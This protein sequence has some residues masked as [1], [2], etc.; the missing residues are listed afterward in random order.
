MT[1]GD[2]TL[3]NSRLTEIGAD[4]NVRIGGRNL[5]LEPAAVVALE[6]AGIAKHKRNA[7][8]RGIAL[9]LAFD[10]CRAGNALYVVARHVGVVQPRE[11]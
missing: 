7:S 4:A 6:M 2:L 10:Q 3:G 11:T 9:L 1:D 8:G 5:A